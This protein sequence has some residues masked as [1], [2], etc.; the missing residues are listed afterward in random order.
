M[1]FTIG[2]EWIAPQGSKEGAKPDPSKPVKVRQERRGN[3]RVTII[4]NTPGPDEK[5]TALA[6]LLKKKCG[7]GGTLKGDVIEIQG[8][9]VEMIKTLLLA[10]GIKSQ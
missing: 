10:E 2:G 8:D 1:P 7:C 6:A 5:R 3:N 9:K 4:V